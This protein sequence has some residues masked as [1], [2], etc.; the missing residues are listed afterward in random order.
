MKDALGVLAASEEERD[1]SAIGAFYAKGRF[2]N[3]RILQP[4]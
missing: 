2:W 3:L 4:L 1:Y